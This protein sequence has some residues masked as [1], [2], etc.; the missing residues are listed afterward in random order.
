[1]VR[2]DGPPQAPVRRS[3]GRRRLRIR[4]EL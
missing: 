2:L 3:S 1:V 4:G